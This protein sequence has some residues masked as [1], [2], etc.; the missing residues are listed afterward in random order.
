MPYHSEAE[1]PARVCRP[2]RRSCVRAGLR[3]LGLALVVA[4][5][6]PSIG[7]AIA[8]DAATA[9]PAGRI[10]VTGEGR[11]AAVPDMA[12]L[13]L[14]VVRE[15]E[16]AGD[17]LADASS[18]A[19]D[20]LAAMAEA[21]IEAR[22]VRT[23]DVSLDPLYGEVERP[24]GTPPIVGYRARNALS[25]RVRDLAALGA[26]IDR[27]VAV[28]ANE[29]G[30]LQLTVSD[31]EALREEAR[32][33]AVEDAAARAAGMAEA[34]GVTLGPLVA[35]NEGGAQPFPPIIGARMAMAESVPIAAGE[36]EITA[37]VT[38]VYAIGE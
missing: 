19:A 8:Q 26:V 10:T 29:G 4:T 28:G 2:V 27:S 14:A 11:V 7:S 30:G 5:S 33:L 16:N 37:S 21:G 17:A 34:A 3:T 36:T 20:V 13:S 23:T 12:T 1:R 31:A 32:R 6:G 18:A 24:R 38:A 22:D 25:V 9:M 15:A 35:L